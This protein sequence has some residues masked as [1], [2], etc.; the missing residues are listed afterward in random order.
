VAPVSRSVVVVG[1]GRSGTSLVAGVL[2]DSGL[3]P[4]DRLIPPSGA[5]PTGFHEDLDVNA[6]NDE[7][8]VPHL[9][10]EHAASGTR[11]AWLAALAP[12]A[13]P[14]ATPAQERRMAEHLRRRP[15]C[16]KDPRLAFTL[17]AWRP[18][19]GPEVCFVAVFRHPAAV[20]RSVLRHAERDPVHFAGFDVTVEQVLRMWTAVNRRILDRHAH[21]GPWLFVDADALAATGDVAPLGRH[22]GAEVPTGRIRPALLSPPAAAAVPPDALALHAELLARRSP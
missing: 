3:H 14:T 6:L 21:Q 1:S 7:L 5:N 9:G 22:V 18:L 17:D 2:V 19:L 4:G 13:V 10:A 11:L 20:V 15:F 12:T 8:L 16:V